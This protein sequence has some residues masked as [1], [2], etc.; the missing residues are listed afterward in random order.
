MARF[1]GE[2]NRHDDILRKNLAL[3]IFYEVLKKKELCYTGNQ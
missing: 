3:F 2:N 1:C